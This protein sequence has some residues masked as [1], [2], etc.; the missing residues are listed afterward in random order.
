LFVIGGVGPNAQQTLQYNPDDNIWESLADIPTPREHLA[1]AEIN[2]RIYAIGGRQGTRS[3]ATV[4][5]YDLLRDTWESFQDAPTA[6]SGIAAAAIDDIVYVV[7]GEALDGSGRTYAELDLL[8]TVN[9][10]WR[11]ATPMP[12]PRHGLA[13]VSIGD[14]LYVPA[15]GRI[16]GLSVSDVV[17][18]YVAD[19]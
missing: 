2:G 18:V 9:Q 5:V 1:A 3:L 14:M 4:E 13:A 12:T 7:G 8:D 11:S 15:G 17:E 19:P 16:A 6:R 10:R